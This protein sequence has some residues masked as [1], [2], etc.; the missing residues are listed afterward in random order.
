MVVALVL[1]VASVAGYALARPAGARSRVAPSAADAELGPT[2]PIPTEAEVAITP[3]PT[4]AT[5]ATTDVSTTDTATPSTVGRS[6]TT[7][8]A[9]PNH[10]AP[11]GSPLPASNPQMCNGSQPRT[12]VALVYPDLNGRN[13]H[14]WTD[15]AG[16]FH[17]YSFC[18]G[19]R[20]SFELAA[21]PV[22]A[23]DLSLVGMYFDQ[24]QAPGTPFEPGTVRIDISVYENCAT[25]TTHPA[26][27]PVP[28]PFVPPPTV[29]TT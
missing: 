26:P 16:T 18:T 9:P 25:T 23:T 1:A 6:T 2:D 20:I 8:P 13:M 4:T 14:A 5:P 3:T 12:P 21:T 15:F 29:P 11:A 10:G 28:P 27:I 22:C 24:R 19:N 7:H 17:W